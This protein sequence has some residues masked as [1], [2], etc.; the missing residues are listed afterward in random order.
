MDYNYHRT[1]HDVKFNAERIS[2][3]YAYD[4]PSEKDG[5]VIKL[6]YAKKMM[7]RNYR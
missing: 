5:R 3:L 7:K 1:L 2:L 4:N 6:Y